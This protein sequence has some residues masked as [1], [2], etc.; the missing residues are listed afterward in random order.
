MVSGLSF[1]EASLG[2]MELATISH[3]SA[4][5]H[6]PGGTWVSLEACIAAKIAAGVDDECNGFRTSDDRW[7]MQ[8]DN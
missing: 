1:I 8:P 4:P 2:G 6:E 5:A 7:A 3:D